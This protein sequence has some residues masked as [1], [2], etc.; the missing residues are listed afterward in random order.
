MSD[1]GKEEREKGRESEG[2]REMRSHF[3]TADNTEAVGSKLPLYS[4]FAV[5]LLSVAKQLG[6][7][8]AESRVRPILGG[9]KPWEQGCI[10][11]CLAGKD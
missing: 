7:F 4:N 3:L 6:L 5:V 11:F 9:E 2:E 1:V 8:S 10:T